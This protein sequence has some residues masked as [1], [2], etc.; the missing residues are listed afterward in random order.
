M[1]GHSNARFLFEN[2][3]RVI[4]RLAAELPDT[5]DTLISGPAGERGV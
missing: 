5:A 3:E 4:A 1:G 2:A